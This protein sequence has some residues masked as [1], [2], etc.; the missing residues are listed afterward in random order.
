[1]ANDPKASDRVGKTDP[2]PLLKMKKATLATL[3]RLILAGSI[4]ALL[5]MRLAAQTTITYAD[6]Q[7]DTTDHSVTAPNDPT[8]LSLAGGFAVQSGLLTGTGSVLKAGAGTLQLTGVNPF[9]GSLEVDAG[10]LS[11]ASDANFGAAGNGV[12][13]VGGTL[14]LSTT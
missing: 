13:L 1:M 4:A 6:G 11:L 5:S 3:P 14:E 12:T 2:F 10:T 7:T 9:S 8:R